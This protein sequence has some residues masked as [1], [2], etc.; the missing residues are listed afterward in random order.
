MRDGHTKKIRYL[1]ASK[2]EPIAAVTPIA[3]VPHIAIRVAPR[4]VDAPP[5]YSA[6]D[7]SAERK[8]SEMPAITGIILARGERKVGRSGARPSCMKLTEDVTAA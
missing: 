7:P 8:M 3:R 4:K 1:T 2:N 5:T 6:N